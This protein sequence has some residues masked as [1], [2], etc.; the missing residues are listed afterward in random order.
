MDENGLLCGW[1]VVK[2]KLFDQWNPCTPSGEG[3]NNIY[4]LTD[5]HF[6]WNSF[7]QSR[8]ET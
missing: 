4:I 8:M 3:H 7:Q 2:H 6:Y 5:H 1:D